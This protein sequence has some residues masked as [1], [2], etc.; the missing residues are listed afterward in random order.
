MIT[1]TYKKA[2][3]F[4]SNLQKRGIDVKWDGWKMVFFKADE[5]AKTD[6]RGKRWGDKWGYE[7]VIAPT[8]KGVWKVNPNF[9]R[10]T[11]D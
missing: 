10:E 3:Q 9:V 4:V 5:R 1:V 11:V 7:A 8:K 6:A 2:D